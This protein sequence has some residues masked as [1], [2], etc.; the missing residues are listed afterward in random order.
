MGNG[1]IRESNVT[2]GHIN[3]VN[4]KF[5]Q[6]I[7]NFLHLGPAIIEL[8]AFVSFPFNPCFFREI[9]RGIEPGSGEI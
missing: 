5:L 2:W 8:L 6:G 7:D 9:R 1:S 4:V 3:H